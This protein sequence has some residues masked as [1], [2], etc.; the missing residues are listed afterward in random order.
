M[1]Q[2]LDPFSIQLHTLVSMDLFFFIFKEFNRNGGK[3][4]RDEVEKVLVFVEIT[5]E[6]LPH[7][8]HYMCPIPFIVYF[9]MFK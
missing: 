9:S 4:D 7:N 8:I 2:R 6:N 1:F 3:S 5:F